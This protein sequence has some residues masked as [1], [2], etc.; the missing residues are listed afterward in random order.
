VKLAQEID[1]V[2]PHQNDPGL[3][4]DIEGNWQ[5]ICRDCHRAKTKAENQRRGKGMLALPDDLP[6]SRVP[7]TIVCGPSGSGKTRYVAEHSKPGDIV[8]DLDKIKAELSGQPWYEADGKK[9]LVP[10]LDRRNQMLTRLA[11]E[12]KAKAAWFVVSAPKPAERAHWERMLRP[13]KIIII[14]VPFDECRRRLKADDRRADRWEH[15]STLAE[16]WWSLFETRDGE[17]ILKGK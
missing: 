12:T 4:W 7:L 11:S 17:T 2:V 6:P 14:A 16:Q 10:A 8:I 13:S 9:W 5:P 1:H 3:F 15:F